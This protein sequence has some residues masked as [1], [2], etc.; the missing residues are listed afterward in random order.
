LGSARFVQRR[1]V[2]L[3]VNPMVDVKEPF[4]EREMH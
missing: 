1:L 3:I 4:I 2:E